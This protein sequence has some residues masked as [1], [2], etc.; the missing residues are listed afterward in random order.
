MKMRFATTDIQIKAQEVLAKALG[1]NFT[2]AMTQ[3]ANTP[4][5][6]EAIGAKPMSL[7]LDLRGGMYFLL[8]IDMQTVLHNR[9]QSNVVSLRSDLRQKRIR[10][11]GMELSKSNQIN[12]RF[13]NQK[14]MDAA[15]DYITGENLGLKLQKDSQNLYI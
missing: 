5:W 11:T 2:V 9:M 12:I 13:A 7:G 8:D 1:S 10:Y 3:Q 15:S 14:N 6:L 4:A